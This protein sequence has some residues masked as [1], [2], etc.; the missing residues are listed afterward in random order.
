MLCVLVIIIIAH[1]YYY[2]L[3]TLISGFLK[4]YL[5]LL[6]FQIMLPRLIIYQEVCSQGPNHVSNLK[7][8]FSFAN[9]LPFC[10]PDSFLCGVL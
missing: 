8:D 1:H 2:L 4:I 3:G 5:Y 10:R 9:S 7:Y 6:S